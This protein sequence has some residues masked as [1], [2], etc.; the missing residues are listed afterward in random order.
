VECSEGKAFLIGP[1]KD[2]GFFIQCP[3]QKQFEPSKEKKLRTAKMILNKI[4]WSYSEESHENYRVGYLDKDMGL[5]EASI[6]ELKKFDFIE[7][8]IKYIK[9]KGVIAWDR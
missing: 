7:N 6:Y 3:S 8:R 1:F 9:K 5:I 2:T 4:I